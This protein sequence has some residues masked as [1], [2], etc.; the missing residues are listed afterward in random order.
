MLR[1]YRAGATVANHLNLRRGRP[2]AEGST[3]KE[4]NRDKMTA[5]IHESQL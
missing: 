4:N 3:N 1:L 5:N 2:A